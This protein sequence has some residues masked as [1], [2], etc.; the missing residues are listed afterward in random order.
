MEQAAHQTYIFLAFESAIA[1][2]GMHRQRDK[3]A[4][5]LSR[6]VHDKFISL[7]SNEQTKNALL[8]SMVLDHEFP[9]SR[10]GVQKLEAI[11]YDLNSLVKGEEGGVAVVEVFSEAKKEGRGKGRMKEEGAGGLEGDK[12]TS[13]MKLQG[14]TSKKQKRIDQ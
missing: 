1:Q 3:L 5:L 12:R 6:L 14:K 9:I 8:G 11:L 13:S 2:L 10:D 4:R 7:S